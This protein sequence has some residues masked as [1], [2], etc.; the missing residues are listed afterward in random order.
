M[1]KPTLVDLAYQHLFRIAYS[2]F[3]Q[4]W[5]VFRPKT[6]GAFVGL[7]WS[8]RVLVLQNSY[9]S[10]R[11]F[12]GGG[13]RRGEEPVDA[14][15]RECAEEVGISISA[16]ALELDFVVH[17]TWEGKRDTVWVYWAELSHEPQ[18]RIDNR[19]VVE[20]SFMEPQ[21]A[22]QSALF[23]PARKHIADRE[24]RLRETGA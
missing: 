13:I 20:A 18:V 10:Y 4:W 2:V 7:W 16:D 21:D 12:P 3:R 15:A 24:A 8:G 19:E 9:V 5:Q 23:A 14:A 11:S 22:L 1:A 17:Q 6:R